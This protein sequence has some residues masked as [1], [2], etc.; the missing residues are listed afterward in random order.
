MRHWLKRWAGAWLLGGA[1]LGAMPSWAGEPEDAL[2]LDR[3]SFGVNA[4]GLADLRRIGRKAWLADQLR[5][6][7]P[8]PLPQAVQTELAAMSITREPASQ[9]LE[10]LLEKRAAFKAAGAASEP[11]L[12]RDMRRSVTELK[13]EAARRTLLRAVHSSRQLQEQLTWFWF[14]HFN[15]VSEGNP[16]LSALMGDYEQR[17]IRSHAMGRFRDLLM[18]VATHPVM[19]VYLNNDRNVADHINENYARELM[20]LHTLGVDGGYTQQ[21]VQ[22]L[23]Q[24]LT[25]LGLRRPTGSPMPAQAKSFSDGMSVFYPGRHVAGAKTLLGTKLEAGG[26]SQ[27]EQ[28]LDLLARQPATARHIARKLAQYFVAD[29]P[30]PALVARLSQRFLDTE[31][32]IAAVMT[33]LVESPEFEASLDHKFKDPVRFVVSAL[34]LTLPADAAWRPQRVQYWL[35]RLGQPLYGRRT[36]DGYP[37]TSGAWAGSGQLAQRFEVAQDI[38]AGTHYPN[39]T[40]RESNLHSLAPGDAFSKEVLLPGL[41]ARSREVLQQASP[42]PQEWRALLLASPEFMTR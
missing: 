10:D 7:A 2:W 6:G 34:R 24:V 39:D 19:L 22:Q 18:A 25:G 8:D 12:R 37:L 28:A 3:L 15:V 5:P 23:A 17:A 4:E 14:N 13:D 31:G 20:E 21:D 40:R 9:L 11:M 42:Q 30:S 35:A 32:D 41:S 38:A 1:L 27:I 33:T 29:E 26:W 36:P 16:E